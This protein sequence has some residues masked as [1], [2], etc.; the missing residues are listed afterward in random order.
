MD[1]KPNKLLAFLQSL[2]IDVSFVFVYLFIVFLLGTIVNF[3]MQFYPIRDFVLMTMRIRGDSIVMF[4][5][6][7]ATML[8]LQLYSLIYAALARNRSTRELAFRI[9][10]WSF[11]VVFAVMGVLNLVYGYSIV[12]N[13]AFVVCGIVML[14]MQ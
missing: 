14:F 11:I 6:L 12:G 4:Q 10:G 9:S 5:L 7:L 1:N 8:V 3:F 2:L 13:I